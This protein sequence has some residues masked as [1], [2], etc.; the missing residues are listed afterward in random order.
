M[1]TCY[2]PKEIEFLL[3]RQHP[4]PLPQ[5]DEGRTT[6]VQRRKSRQGSRLYQTNPAA[7]IH[8]VRVLK[9]A[10]R[11]RVSLIAVLGGRVKILRRRLRMSR[12]EL[13]P[14]LETCSEDPVELGGAQIPAAAF[15]RI[16]TLF[17]NDGINPCLEMSPIGI[18]LIIHIL[19]RNTT[20]V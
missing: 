14:C 15:Y 5:H 1:L 6:D 11:S 13:C 3:R 9:E 12:N 8:P 20:G 18:V 10:F 7:V 19:L 17:F 2:N 16:R 4:K